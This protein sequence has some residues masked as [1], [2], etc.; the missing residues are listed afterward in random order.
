MK[1]INKLNIKRRSLN[2]RNEKDHKIFISNLI[3]S[4]PFVNWNWG[5]VNDWFMNQFP[6]SPKCIILPFHQK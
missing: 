5:E 3:E 6:N 2:K 4:N 1:N